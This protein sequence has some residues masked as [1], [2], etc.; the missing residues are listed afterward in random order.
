MIRKDEC[1]PKNWN[2]TIII[3]AHCDSSSLKNYRGIMLAKILSNR[4]IPYTD[5]YLGEYLC[6]FRK[7]RSK[8]EHL[9]GI[10]RLM[11]YSNYL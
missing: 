1:M 5:E 2:E 6:G 4:M 11:Y 3:P 9:S 7:W 8:V 10:D